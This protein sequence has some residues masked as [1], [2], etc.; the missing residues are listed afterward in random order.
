MK[1]KNV[2]SSF[3]FISHKRMFRRRIYFFL[4]Y[5][6]DMFCFSSK[7]ANLSSNDSKCHYIEDIN[8][9]S[10]GVW[11]W[12]VNNKTYDFLDT[13]TKDNDY[14]YIHSG[15]AWKVLTEKLDPS[16][17][18]CFEHPGPLTC[19]RKHAITDI[20]ATIYPRRY[21]IILF[22]GSCTSYHDRDGKHLNS[23]DLLEN[24]KNSKTLFLYEN[25]KCD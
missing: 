23:V 9:I 10:F 25:K 14:R 13:Y 11:W 16:H 8:V 12:R 5:K 19:V 21:R 17:F 18:I 4:V 2:I 20:A 1:I 15:E 6:G 24:L 22:D 3:D 7:T